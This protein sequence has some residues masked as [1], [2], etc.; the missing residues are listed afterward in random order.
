MSKRVSLYVLLL[1]TVGVLL[2]HLSVRQKDNGYLLVVT[3][4]EVD[5]LGM[6]HEKWV[7][8]TRQCDKVS[9]LDAAS[10]QHQKILQS[11][12]AYSPPHSGSANVVSLLTTDTWALAEVEFKELLPAVVVLQ[13]SD[14]QPTSV[15]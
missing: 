9:K 6:A 3:E 8:M 7:R 4:R 11:I 12:Q 13:L 14:G 1:V 10:T 15:S 2:S 5:V